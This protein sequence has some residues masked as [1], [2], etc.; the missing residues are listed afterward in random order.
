MRLLLIPILLT[1]TVASCSTAT[2]ADRL[3]SAREAVA[4]RDYATAADL[5]NG[6]S[7]GIDT[8][9]AHDLCALSVIYMYI[10]EATSDDDLIASAAS[11]YAR[12]VSRDSLHT[13]SYFDSVQVAD[14]A[15]LMLLDQIVSSLNAPRD[16]PA[17]T[18]P[19]DTI[20]A[21]IQL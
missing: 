3:D 19:A 4:R 8:L 13:A 11:C 14:A 18:I 20:P 10:A 16:I 6:I 15:H 5:C 21:D 2:T 17:D 1:L 7:A 12:A 9:S